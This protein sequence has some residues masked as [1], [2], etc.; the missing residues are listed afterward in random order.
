MDE[1]KKDDMA[2]EKL[3]VKD[4]R[5]AYMRWHFANEILILLKDI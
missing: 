2:P 5:K 4:V 3:D 1:I